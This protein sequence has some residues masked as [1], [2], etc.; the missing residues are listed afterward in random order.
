MGNR[1]TRYRHAYRCYASVMLL[2]VIMMSMSAI[3][4]ST[5][6]DPFGVFGLG[7][8]NS[9]NME[10]NTRY[11]KIEYLKRHPDHSGFV[12]GTSRSNAYRSKLLTALTGIPYYNM[13]GQSDTP[14]GMFGKLRWL[15]ENVAPRQILIGLDFDELDQPLERDP[16][17][18]QRREHPEVEGITSAAFFYDYFWPHPKHL[19]L[20][21]YGNFVADKTWYRYWPEKGRHDFPYY[22]EF[23]Q[24]DPEGYVAQRLSFISG[25]RPYLPNPEQMTRLA[26]LVVFAKKN[27][28]KTTLIVNPTNHRLFRSY[29]A[30]AYADWLKRL[31]QLGGE[32]WDFSGL[33]SVTQDDLLYYDISHFTET[34]GDMVLRR[35]YGTPAD[36]R[37]LPPD[38]GVLVTADNVAGRSDEMYRQLSGPDPVNSGKR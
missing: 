31:V 26:E 37:H 17:D 30:Q 4:V 12:F 5:V 6:I 21:I 19:L 36:Q 24:K 11:L 22:R 32:V 34:I 15:V 18:L 16:L 20:T 38:F 13:N 25:K 7:T 9:R 8:V 3:A 33:N 29:R 23:M 2:V 14:A 1:K 28:I 10:P 27:N 35:I